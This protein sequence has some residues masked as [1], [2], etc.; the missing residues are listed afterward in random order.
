MIYQNYQKTVL[1]GGLTIVSEHIS[2]VR[3]VSL[4]VWVKSGTRQEDRAHNGVAHFL[5]H[6]MFKKTARRSSREIVRSV[7]TLG[8]NLNAF[9][10][11]EQ[12]CYYADIL[13][14]NLPRAVTVLAD[15][16]H[17]T[18]FS[19]KEFEK[20]REVILD[21]I[22][23]LE[24]SPDDLIHDQFEELFFQGHSLGLPILG[25]AESIGN[26]QMCDLLDFYQ[27]HYR[28]GN[29]VVAAAGNLDHQE[30]IDLVN[31]KF[32]FPPGAL[33]PPN[34]LPQ[35][36]CRGH[37]QYHRP[38]SQSHVC[39]GFPGYSFQ[40]PHRYEALVLNTILGEG[41]GSRLFQ[42]IRERHGI[43]YE[44]YSFL[45]SYY[46]AGTFGVYLGTDRRNVARGLGLV[47]R[48]LSRLRSR[49]IPRKELQEAQSQLKGNMVIS[50]ESTNHRMN[51]LAMMEIYQGDFKTLD[52]IVDNIN[53]VTQESLLK[54]AQEMLNPDNLLEIIYLPEE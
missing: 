12:T 4:A 48:E 30:L 1:P 36:F 5:E 17:R 25:N 21:E 2:S 37:F 33:P 39:L 31:S 29:I 44:L 42:N 47:E 38:V 8:G 6:M 23:S 26:L 16:L 41:M 51:R 10:A 11:K 35:R 15:I 7:E 9:T 50:L 46:D 49:P 43:A 3:S 14:E 28:Q 24:D 54:A 18:S 19:Q 22:R 13:D 45:D 40:H 32:D 34:S 20:E 27:A 53:R 52:S